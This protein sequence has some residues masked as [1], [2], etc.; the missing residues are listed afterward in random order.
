MQ[1]PIPANDGR[2]ICLR[3]VNQVK[4]L[5]ASGRRATRKRKGAMKSAL[6]ALV[7]FGLIYLGCSW[8]GAKDR[9]DEQEM[10]RNG[11][12]VVVSGATYRDHSPTTPYAPE[13]PRPA[14][15]EL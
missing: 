7:Y 14:G 15:P 5:V 1:L 6:V 4:R 3:I 12:W 2:S 13:F 11:G 8:L 10:K 9:I